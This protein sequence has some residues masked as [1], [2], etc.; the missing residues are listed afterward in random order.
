MAPYRR[1]FALPLIVALSFDIANQFALCQTTSGAPAT[2]QKKVKAPPRDP[3]QYEVQRVGSLD[4]LPDLPHYT[5]HMRFVMGKCYPNHHRGKMYNFMVETRESPTQVIDW[6][7]G[8]LPGNGWRVEPNLERATELSA[9][10]SSGDTLELSVYTTNQK[11]WPTGIQM[12]YRG[13]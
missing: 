3:R 8:A 7:K 5:G 9:K 4:Q 10:H 2:P 1:I 11:D 12:L 13:K 6:Y